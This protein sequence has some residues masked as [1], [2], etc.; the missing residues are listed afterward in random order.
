[1]EKNWVGQTMETKGTRVQY[2]L[3]T[4]SLDSGRTK[5]LGLINHSKIEFPN[6]ALIGNVELKL[7]TV[8]DKNE[9]K[10]QGTGKNIKK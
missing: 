7:R 1:M 5:S 9:R 6:F 3:N 10:N 4:T 2:F 8:E